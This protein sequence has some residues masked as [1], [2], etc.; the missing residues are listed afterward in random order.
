M[1]FTLILILVSKN[2]QRLGDMAAGTMV[3]KDVTGHVWQDESATTPQPAAW[4][5][6]IPVSPAPPYTPQPAPA[7]I[8]PQPA[9]TPDA[10]DTAFCTQCGQPV[11]PQKDVFC[12]ACGNR[13]Q[14]D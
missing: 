5:P 12:R 13:V 4:Y 10:D 9:A 3:V 7:P 1:F 2:A 11:D 6:P 14:G 8:P